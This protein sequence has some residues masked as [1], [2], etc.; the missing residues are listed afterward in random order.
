MG[1]RR[2]LCFIILIAT[3]LGLGVTGYTQKR[4]PDVEFVPTPQEVVLEMLKM[5]KVTQNDVVYDLGCGDGRIVIT[6]ANVFGARGVGVDIDPIRI[7]ESNK[8]ARKACVTDRVKFIEGDLFATDLT[9]ATVVTLYLTPELNI[10]V[11]PKL[12]RELTPGTRIVSHDFDMGGWK[13]DKMG[14]IRNVRYDY[15]DLNYVRDAPF[16]YWII[17][18]N[19]AG[20]WRWSLRTSTGDR[21]CTLRL[22]QKFQEISGQ[23]SGKGQGVNIDDT[24]LVGDQLSFMLRSEMDKQNVVMHFS[25]RVSGDTIKGSMAVLG[26]TF[27]SQYKWTARRDH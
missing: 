21:P 16:Y 26:G 20:T 18:A 27:S 14:L 7:W 4:Q 24:R 2:T 17:P 11:Q 10:Q 19:V 5:A 15:P 1:F 6:A 13:P 25:G 22:S 12:F 8:N 9:E 23:V 3:V